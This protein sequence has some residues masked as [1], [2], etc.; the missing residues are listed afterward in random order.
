MFLGAWLM[1]T[2]KALLVSDPSVA[3]NRAIGGIC[4]S[5]AWRS[6]LMGGAGAGAGA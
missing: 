4:F 6:D 5:P 1:D 3:H 2:V